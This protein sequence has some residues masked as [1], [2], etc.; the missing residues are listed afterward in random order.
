MDGR[1][2]AV[3]P[4]LDSW[5]VR[6]HLAWQSRFAVRR[7]GVSVFLCGAG[8]VNMACGARPHL[9]FFVTLGEAWCA[10]KDVF[11]AALGV[12]GLGG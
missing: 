7:C 1:T 12:V 3:G 6:I 2:I 11:C 9:L 10:R 5:L 4:R 8:C